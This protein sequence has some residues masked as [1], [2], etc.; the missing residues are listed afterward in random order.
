[1]EEPVE[2]T[3]KSQFSELYGQFFIDKQNLKSIYYMDAVGAYIKAIENGIA[4]WQWKVGG[5]GGW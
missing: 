4:E 5:R 1:M 3:S 2:Y